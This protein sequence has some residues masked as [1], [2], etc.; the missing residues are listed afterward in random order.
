MMMPMPCPDRS[1]EIGYTISVGSQGKPPHLFLRGSVNP[2]A[3]AV[4]CRSMGRPV[5]ARAQL[6]SDEKFKR[7]R[8]SVRRPMSRSN[9]TENERKVDKV[10]AHILEKVRICPL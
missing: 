10:R 3:S 7:V 1:T 9:Y 8:Q 2:R 5:P 6:P 4:K